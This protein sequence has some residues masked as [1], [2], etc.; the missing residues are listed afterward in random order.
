M[1]VVHVDDFAIAASTE[2]IKTEFL[3]LIRKRYKVKE[4]Q[5]SVQSF[6]DIHIDYFNDGSV[7]FSQ[8]AR[9]ADIVRTYNLSNTKP[10]IVPMC[11]T[12][13]NDLFPK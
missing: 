7:L 12:F 5:S 3:S 9:I 11:S 10:P 13:N 6:L 4:C 1:L 8:P 2:E